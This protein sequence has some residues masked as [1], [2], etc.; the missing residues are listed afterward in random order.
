[1]TNCGHRCP[2]PVRPVQVPAVPVNA[3]ADHVIPIE[4]QADLL[5]PVNV[6]VDHVVPIK[7]PMLEVSST[8]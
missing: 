2:I 8:V 5:V 1:M 4:D 7:A 6:P 3:P